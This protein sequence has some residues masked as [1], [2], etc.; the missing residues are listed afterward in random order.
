MPVHFGFSP[1]PSP[2][3]P[4]FG[5]QE[6][7]PTPPLTESTEHT[8]TS[9]DAAPFSFKLGMGTARS[10]IATMYNPGP[11][12]DDL[13]TVFQ[14]LFQ[15]PADPS[16]LVP[17]FQGSLLTKRTIQ[18]IID[19][20]DKAIPK[21]AIQD[22]AEQLVKA[23]NT[24][25]LSSGGNIP[26]KQLNEATLQESRQFFSD[27]QKELTA[28]LTFLK[29]L[30][31][32]K[33]GIEAY[34]E[35]A[36]QTLPLLGLMA[37]PDAVP[38][39]MQVA[40]AAASITQ[41]QG[42]TLVDILQAAE[43]GGTHDPKI[44]GSFDNL[45]G[46]PVIAQ[47]IGAFAHS[48]PQ[49]VKAHQRFLNSLPEGDRVS[50]HTLKAGV[51]YGL[52]VN[53]DSKWVLKN[54][55]QPLLKGKLP[56]SVYDEVVRISDERFAAIPENQEPP[57]FSKATRNQLAQTRFDTGLFTIQTRALHQAIEIWQQQADC[58]AE[59]QSK[60]PKD[61]LNDF[62]AGN[63][64]DKKAA[65]FIRDQLLKNEGIQPVTVSGLSLFNNSMEIPEEI[66]KPGLALRDA[67]QMLLSPHK[68]A[69]A[70][71]NGQTLQDRM[72]SYLQSYEDNISNVSKAT[73]PSARIF[74]RDVALSI[75]T[76]ME[77]MTDNKLQEKL[78]ANYSEL[79][80]QEQL[81]SV[82]QLVGD[83][84]NWIR[85]SD[86][87]NLGTVDLWTLKPDSNASNPEKQL[88]NTTLTL[89]ES[90]LRKHYEHV[91]EHSTGLFG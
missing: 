62:L 41:K 23:A 78:P 89:G 54:A 67:D 39:N 15:S 46:H 49:V 4:K 30:G 25:H 45:A 7:S 27:V 21:T 74:Q 53:D 2:I 72:V 65:A 5:N 58:P 47:T 66:R 37:F 33:E 57:S 76:A 34:K 75:V 36:I 86:G 51:I 17:D 13:E 71:H 55:I 88:A 64:T 20:P 82:T 32:S 43:V 40:R 19:E 79:S 26:T 87:L 80:T 69:L 6:A 11:N 24:R 68:I 9:F 28:T 59:F 38:H 22:F 77:E 16:V 10:P 83:S 73:E 63:I 44:E 18:Q 70:V 84:D 35:Y 50:S 90:T 12:Q 14:N 42:G 3:F 8:P 85:K 52:S 81:A 56:E 48:N 31:I 1:V 29:E 91:L 61:V 60:A